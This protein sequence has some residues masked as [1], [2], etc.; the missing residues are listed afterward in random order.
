[1]CSSDLGSAEPLEGPLAAE[2]TMVANAKKA[3]LMLAGA[4]SQK[5]MMAIS[6]QQEIM[7]AIA[8][9]VI[10]GYAMDSVVLR[11]QKLIERQGEA[12][13]KLAI[14][15]AQ[16]SITLSMEKIEAAAKKVV[17]AVSEG[18]MLRTQLV[19]L[20]RLFK[21]EPFNLIGLTQ[22]IANRII[23]AGKYVTS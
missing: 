20:R 6:D 17:A 7:G 18:D 9:M 4:A 10:E 5:Y 22:Q 2:R 1:V 23:E 15:M 12:R 8:D 21:Y 14:A 13:S 3:G 11:T 16:V 19:I